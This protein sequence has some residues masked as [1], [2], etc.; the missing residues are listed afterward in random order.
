MADKLIKMVCP[1]CSKGEIEVP[2]S[3]QRDKRKI[4]KDA[5]GKRMCVQLLHIE[6]YS[7]RE[8]M[9]M[10]NY[11]SPSSVHKIIV[12]MNLNNSNGKG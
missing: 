8:I 7:V 12:D 5:I 1:I 3:L 11:K 9:K 6:G 2:K 10:L 4:S